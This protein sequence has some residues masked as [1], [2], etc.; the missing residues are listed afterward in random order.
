M[1]PAFLTER[2]VGTFDCNLCVLMSAIY[3]ELDSFCWFLKS[4]TMFSNLGL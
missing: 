2:G 3:D 1:H 4:I